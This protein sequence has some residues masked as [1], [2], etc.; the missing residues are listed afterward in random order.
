[1]SC[2]TNA[3]HYLKNGTLPEWR[4][5]KSEIRISKPETNPN[6]EMI[7]IEDPCGQPQGIFEMYGTD[8]ILL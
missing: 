5:W 6:I 2:P 1:V 4:E 3:C 8:S 7:K